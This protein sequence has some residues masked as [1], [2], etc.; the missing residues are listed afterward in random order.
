MNAKLEDGP[1]DED[2]D[3]VIVE[4][5][6]NGDANNLIKDEVEVDQLLATTYLEVF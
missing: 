3:H 1:R 2:E 4:V 6:D 5:D